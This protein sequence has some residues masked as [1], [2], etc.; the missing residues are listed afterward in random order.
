MGSDGK[1]VVLVRIAG[2]VL[3]VERV[4]KGIR[5]RLLRRE[6]PGEVGGKPLD[7]SRALGLLRKD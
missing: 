4:V 5:A 6:Q 3:A 1:L 2:R 7:Q